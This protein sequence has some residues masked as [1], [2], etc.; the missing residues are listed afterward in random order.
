MSLEFAYLVRCTDT[1]AAVLARATE[2][3]PDVTLAGAFASVTA[4]PTAERD[5]VVVLEAT[6]LSPDTEYPAT[7]THDGDIKNVTLRTLPTNPDEI[8]VG[9]GSCWVHNEDSNHVF[10]RIA[11]HR[12]P[13]FL[14]LGDMHYAD[15]NGGDPR[16]I[17]CVR[18]AT[19]NASSAP[20]DY[21]LNC[22]RHHRSIRGKSVFM[23][24]FH[25]VP[26]LY[27]YDDHEIF[28]GWSWTV[29]R[30]NALHDS[31]NY[32]GSVE[33]IPNSDSDADKKTK[34]KNLYDLARQSCDDYMQGNF[35]N[36][37][38]DIDQYPAAAYFAFRIGNLVEFIFFDAISYRNHH[39]ATSLYDEPWASVLSEDNA[40]RTFLG[41]TG[42]GVIPE[43]ELADDPNAPYQYEWLKARLLAAQNDGIPHKIVASPRKTFSDPEDN[44]DSFGEYTHERNELLAWI[45]A[46]IT[47]CSWT[48]GDRHLAAIVAAQAADGGP[49]PND[50][51]DHLCV[52]ACPL[53]QTVPTGDQGLY[54]FQ[55]QGNKGA[56]TVWRAGGQTG[57]PS[58][59][60]PWGEIYRV[61]GEI[62]I[63]REYVEWRLRH[64]Y[65][66]HVVW[67][68]RVYAGS[69]ALT[70]PRPRL[71]G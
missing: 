43:P 64:V 62:H 60:P 32:T 46:N 35:A 3:T 28:D 20:A 69:N 37:D 26:M 31:G 39:Q 34:L 4:T 70:Y 44:G 45:H 59:A 53:G 5:N 11:Q 55:A 33:Q 1:T 71:A 27:M 52:N 58:D 9:Y 36:T 50:G 56:N 19:I 17:G 38:D 57:F 18:G 40:D 41:R 47:G 16:G 24:A 22:R 65:T 13:L 7:V 14:L 8:T 10:R 6:G 21:L 29:A 63:T 67:S 2:T 42:K 23:K 49:Y 51:Y 15:A 48:G 12:Y 25:Q 30:A 66:D 68:G 54:G 61:I